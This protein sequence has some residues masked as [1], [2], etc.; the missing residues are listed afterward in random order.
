MSSAGTVTDRA[1]ADLAPAPDDV[2][3]RAIT[4]I[5]MLTADAVEA[6]NSGHPG[7]PMGMAPCGWVLW[8]RF[9]RF[10]PGRPDWPDRD[11]FVLSAGHGSMLLYSLL[12]LFGYDLP[13]EEIKRFRQ[14]HSATP[15][16]PEYW[17]APGVETTTGPLGQ[18]FG[19]AVGMA[20][21]E[22]MLAARFNP[23]DGETIVDH[24]TYVFA[25]DGDLMEG[26]SH[27]GASLAGHL[28]LGR[29]IVCYDDNRVTI[30][31]STD[32][33]Y[34]DDPCAR[35]DAY[36]WH[37][38]TVE[39]ANDRD[40]LAAALEAA[41]AEEERPSLIRIHTRIGFGAPEV[42][43]THEAH[44]G[45]LGE[46]QLRRTKE[47]FGWPPDESFVV[48][49]D[50][51]ARCREVADAGRRRREDWEARFDEWAA[52]HPEQAD[53]WRRAHERRL[54]AGLDEALPDHFDPDDRMATRDGSGAVL[55]SIGELMPELVGGS[56]DLAG[57]NRTAKAPGGS[58][59]RG[60]YR[61][62]KIHFGVREHNMAAA[63]N[64]LALHG[65]LRPYGATFMVFS[66]YARP[67]IRLAALMEA[68][69]ILIFTH[70]SVGVGEDGPT[71][72]P[73][74]HLNA[75]RA[76]PGL[77]LLR[78]ADAYEAVDVWRIALER[79][80]GPTAMALSRQKVPVLEQPPPGAIAR[81]G[82]WVIR[83]SDDPPE[84]VLV[85]TGSEVWVALEAADRLA[86][87]GVQVRVVSMPWR[88][89]F[90]ELP[91]DR[92]AEILPPTVPRVVV[93]AGSPQGWEGL[94]SPPGAPK[95]R[96]IGLKRFG[97][98]APGADVL[99]D[100]GFTPEAVADAARDLLAADADRTAAGDT[101]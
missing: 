33:T 36:H 23:D 56:A 68:P 53:A 8:T 83:D 15:G 7:M 67:S 71:H 58:V 63:L 17:C 66:D 80:D 3:G 90:G 39:D 26:V 31:G 55:S 6:A 52:D 87:D 75:L 4:T 99:A 24:R 54:P 86:E 43:G 97:A 5:R 62:P 82:A 16:H 28:G 14:L 34:S 96:I 35:F 41:I 77:A 18:G 57:S 48:P 9:L 73:V 20:L 32:L 10:D 40:A 89:K 42:E 44:D 78:P 25:S 61:G 81:N 47:R 30:D 101:P 45:A 21:A 72:Q 88:E 19:N 91:H 12:H 94:A 64:G 76:I 60:D 69:V 93:E 85:A 49:D 84:V 13:M 50:V 27:E 100:L 92:A 79:T 74:E 2:D 51:R 1:K 65:G 98:S 46:E 70:D 11:R 95:G 29:L 59:K 22:R 37:T 38:Q